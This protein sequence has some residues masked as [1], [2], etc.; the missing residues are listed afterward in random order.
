MERPE[1]RLKLEERLIPSSSLADEIGDGSGMQESDSSA[2]PAVVLGA[3]VAVRGVAF[4]TF[5]VPATKGR[6]LEE[7][8][9]SITKL[10]GR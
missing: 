4:V 8:Q 7:I 3:L 5:L 9:A 10:S 6:T 2:T 1:E